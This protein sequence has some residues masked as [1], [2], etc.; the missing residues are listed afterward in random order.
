MPTDHW[1]ASKA[2]NHS[3]GPGMAEAV[4][5]SSHSFSLSWSCFYIYDVHPFDVL[6]SVSWS[7][8]SKCHQQ[9]PTVKKTINDNV[10]R[11]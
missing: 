2:G 11:Y 5:C 3:C 10:C 8:W 7:F 4:A 6:T 9:I 1:E